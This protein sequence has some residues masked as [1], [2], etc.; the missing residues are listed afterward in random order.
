MPTVLCKLWFLG[1]IQILATNHE[2]NRY[3]IKLI[4]FLNVFTAFKYHKLSNFTV[5]LNVENNTRLAGCVKAFYK[6]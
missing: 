5:F 4:Y 3:V 1:M 6:T 2:A